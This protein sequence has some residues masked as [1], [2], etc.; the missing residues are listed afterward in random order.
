M[1]P[2]FAKYMGFF[3][4]GL[5]AVIGFI[6]LR[7]AGRSKI[8]LD[9]EQGYQP[10]HEATCGGH[11]GWFRYTYPFIRLAV[12]PGFM[13]IASGMNSF[14]LNFEDILEIKP[15]IMGGFKIVHR[16][17]DIPKSIRIY[18]MTNNTILQIL[19]EQTGKVTER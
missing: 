6:F 15:L 9:I 10:I 13:V 17:E 19:A 12:Y 1:E 8:R 4:F 18:T 3:V 14:A 5:F 7:M 16:R 11:I 2:F